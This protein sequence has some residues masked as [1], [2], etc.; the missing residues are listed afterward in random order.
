[1]ILEHQICPLCQSQNRV[2]NGTTASGK[3]KISGLDCKADRLLGSS[4]YTEEKT[5]PIL[6][7]DP[8]TAAL[9]NWPKIY[10]LAPQI[11]I[12]WI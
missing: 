12:N 9:T 10:G 5:E 3:Q 8:E 1:M 6:K 4:R 2:Q 7:T 11:V